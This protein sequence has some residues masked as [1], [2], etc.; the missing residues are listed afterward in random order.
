M[1]IYALPVRITPRLLAAL[2]DRSASL[3]KNGV[4][5]LLL[6]LDAC[7][8]HAEGERAPLERH[9]D[10]IATGLHAALSDALAEVRAT[11]RTA[12]WALHRHFPTRCTRL[13]PSLD[14]S[15]HKLVLEEQPRYEASRATGVG[16]SIRGIVHGGSRGAVNDAR[17]GA[18]APPL[19]QLSSASSLL[20]RQSSASSVHSSASNGDGPLPPSSAATAAAA[21]GGSAR[22]VPSGGSTRRAATPGGDGRPISPRDAA[23]SGCD[24][25][26]RVLPA[27]SQSF[28]RAPTREAHGA[29]EAAAVQMVHVAQVAHGAQGAQQPQPQ[30]QPQLQ[31]RRATAEVRAEAA[32][33]AEVA[34]G[35]QQQQRAGE[36]GRGPEPGHA[37]GGGSMTA[38]GG[39]VAA[40]GDGM[41]E[42]GGSG[43]ACGAAGIDVVLSKGGSSMWSVRAQCCDELSVLAS[44]PERRAELLPLVDKAVSMIL[45]RL[46]DPHYRVVNAALSASGAL[47]QH[48]PHA[49]EPALERLFPQLLLRAQEARDATRR[50]SQVD[51][52]CPCRPPPR[53][54]IQTCPHASVRAL[55]L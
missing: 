20:G 11:S 22:R 6:L 43:G 54:S 42:R 15:T 41:A 31:V 7:P 44:M 19:R 27:R 45:E 50:A 55:C 21:G 37:V 13:L 53:A 18:G 24:G 10:A 30:P 51:A 12:F 47:A 36:L 9:A 40:G 23:L 48:F 26:G 17:T 39:G 25:R 38:G 35:A 14:A 5:Y 29:H 1:L 28:G 34:E 16:P 52:P 3:R 49:L 8:T 4:Q 33:A 2:S 46:C 32:E